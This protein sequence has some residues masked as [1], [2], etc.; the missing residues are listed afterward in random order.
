MPSTACSE[1]VLTSLGSSSS[2][3]STPACHGKLRS[4]SSLADVH[5]ATIKRV[6]D[7]KPVQIKPLVKLAA[8][9]DVKASELLMVVGTKS[10][11]AVEAPDAA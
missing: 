8:H 10:M 6:E 9:F 4:A 7:G 3:C 2:A 1:A 11:A 5:H